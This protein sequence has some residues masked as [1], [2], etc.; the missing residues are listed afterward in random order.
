MK[1]Q[2]NAFGFTVTVEKEGWMFGVSSNP[3]DGEFYIEGWDTAFTYLGALFKGWRLARL[4]AKSDLEEKFIFIYRGTDWKENMV[5]LT[6]KHLE[7][8]R[9]VRFFTK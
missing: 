4:H 3:E 6:C 9:R 8:K 2:F 1:T 7:I 5:P